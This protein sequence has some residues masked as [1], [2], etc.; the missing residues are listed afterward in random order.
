MATLIKSPVANLR[1]ATVAATVSN[2]LVAVHYAAATVTITKTVVLD[3][4]AVV[5]AAVM[6]KTPAPVAMGITQ[7]NISGTNMNLRAITEIIEAKKTSFL[8]CL[9]MTIIYHNFCNQDLSY[10][11]TAVIVWVMTKQKG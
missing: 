9:M 10:T 6:I 8:V 4:K 5:A 2:T 11:M 7:M 3:Y 1:L